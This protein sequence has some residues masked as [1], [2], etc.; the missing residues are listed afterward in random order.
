ME[1]FKTLCRKC[2]A[3]IG[4]D[5]VQHFVYSALICFAFGWIRPLYVPVVIALSFGLGKEVYDHFKPQPTHDHVHD[6]ICDCAGI[7]FG[8]LLIFINSLAK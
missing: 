7:A 4:G 6:V 2:A 8:L 3:W 1:K 5:G